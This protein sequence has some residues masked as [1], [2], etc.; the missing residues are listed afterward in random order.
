MS[1]TEK[2]AQGVWM[3]M[4]NTFFVTFD[5]WSASITGMISALSVGDQSPGGK[6]IQRL[7]QL[8]EYIRARTTESSN[9][10][11]RVQLGYT[12]KYQGKIFDEDKILSELSPWIRQVTF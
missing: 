11:R 9:L 3:A 5:A 7:D 12:L 1:V 8:K 2:Y 6:F 4:A 10:G